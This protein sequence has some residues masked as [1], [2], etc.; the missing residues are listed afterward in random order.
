MEGSDCRP[1]CK[2]PHTALQKLVT[3]DAM[4]YT[5]K[6]HYSREKKQETRQQTVF[7]VGVLSAPFSLRVFTRQRTSRINAA[8]GHRSTHSPPV[9]IAAL[10]MCGL[11]NMIFVMTVVLLVTAVVLVGVRAAIV[12]L[13]V[14]RAVT[15]TLPMVV[16]GGLAIR[17]RQ[18]LGVLHE[19]LKHPCDRLLHIIA[20]LQL[21]IGGKVRQMPG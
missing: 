16:V 2:T 18:L 19:I 17:Q 14:M 4:L 13:V 6:S 5:P 3:R 7:A 12:V 15:V 1:E 8:L 11:D 21:H 20:I 9:I 10:S